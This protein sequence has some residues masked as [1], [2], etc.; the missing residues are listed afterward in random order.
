MVDKRGHE[1]VQEAV[2][3]ESKRP[4]LGDGT[5][6]AAAAGG[7]PR[8]SADM[9]AKLEKTKKLLQAQKELQEKLKKLPQ[10]SAAG[11]RRD[12]LPLLRC[13]P[14]AVGLRATARLHKP[15]VRRLSSPRPLLQQRA[16]R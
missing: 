13:A 11:R 5:A 7:A 4:K 14:R 12:A 15:P 2:V 8:V 10:A 9:L 1:D 3:P 16:C 6:T